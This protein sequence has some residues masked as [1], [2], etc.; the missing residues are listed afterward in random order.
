MEIIDDPIQFE[1]RL[2]RDKFMSYRVWAEIRGLEDPA[3]RETC[4]RCN[5]PLEPLST[6]D[7]EFFTLP[8]WDCVG[9]KRTERELVVESVVRNIRDFYM[10]KVLG[11]RYFQLFLIDP[12]YFT[13]TLPHVYPEF[14]KV[15]SKLNPPSRNDIWFL[16]W[17][18]GFPKI[19][20]TSN[21]EGLKIVNLSSHYN[22]ELDKKV[23]KVDD[24][25]IRWPEEIRTGTRHRTRYG[26]FSQ[27]ND[28]RKSKRL[29]LGDHCYQLYNTDNLNI[30]S[31][32][33]LYR[34]G[35]EVAFR[36]LG[37]QDYVILKLALLR[38]RSFLKFVFDILSELTRQISIFRDAVFLKNT[39]LIDPKKTS[40]L[41]LVWNPIS[42]E[43]MDDYVNISLLS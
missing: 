42:D 41:N 9:K 18:P 34:K 21:L 2:I 10:G 39:V 27:G 5:K 15:I 23:V 35:E 4:Y 13:N 8:C 24:Y 40:K 17:V 7:P 6:L 33:K 19:I 25:E 11:D 30:K 28:N 16:D 38:D 1:R 37:Y 36:S 14:K 12:I 31:I 26:I 3:K 43:V 20:T 32:F 29:K 22:I